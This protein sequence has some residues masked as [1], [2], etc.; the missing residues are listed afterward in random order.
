MD[1]LKRISEEASIAIFFR[2]IASKKEIPV[3]VR[4][5]EKQ[6]EATMF[7]N[8]R[9]GIEPSLGF[10]N[11]S[12]DLKPKENIEI[13][14]SNNGIDFNFKTEITSSFD[15]I[16][17]IEIP[18][19]LFYSFSSINSDD[20]T[21]ESFG[22][23]YPGFKI[24]DEKAARDI[25]RENEL[26]K[27]NNIINLQKIIE[28]GS[29]AKGIVSYKNEK[30]VAFGS[31]ARINNKTFQGSQIISEYDTKIDTNPLTILHLGL[32]N[33]LINNADFEHYIS[34]MDSDKE[35]ILN[36]YSDAEKLINDENKFKIDMFE[37]IECDCNNYLPSN[38]SEDIDCAK[39]ENDEEFLEFCSRSIKPIECKSYSYN[40]TDLY[41]QSIKKKYKDLGLVAERKIWR[42]QKHGKVLA[43]AVAESYPDGIIQKG[44]SDLCRIHLTN[45]NADLLEILDALIK[46]AKVFFEERNKDTF[47]IY[48]KAGKELSAAKDIPGLKYREPIVRVLA[49]KDGLIEYK[50]LLM[51]ELIQ[52]PKNYPLTQA[53]LAIWQTEK[54]YPGT[55]FGNIPGIV[56]I[57]EPIDRVQLE[58]AINLVI[59]NNDG[60]RIKINEENGLPSQFISKYKYENFDYM[61]FSKS[62]GLKGLYKWDEYKNGSVFKL[63]DSEL[64]YFTIFKLSDNEGGFYIKTHHLISDAWTSS[65]LIISKV[66]EL[67]SSF[68]KPG[69]V[70]K[71]MPSY[72]DYI[73]SENDYKKSTVFK[74]N[75]E[76]WNS[77]F[78]TVPELIDL[79]PASSLYK[80]T[81]AGR[82]S[83]TLTNQASLKINEFCKNTGSSPFSVFLS[84]LSVYMER[85][86]SKGDLVLG[87]PILNRSNFREKQTTG[88]FISTVPVRLNVNPKNKFN[89]FLTYVN[90][91]WKQILKNQ[92]YPY[93]LILD[94]FRKKNKLNTNLYDVV[95]SYQNTSHIKAE[96]E[97]SVDW[98]FNHSQTCSLAI[99][100]SNRDGDDRYAIDY[101]YLVDVF[102]SEEIERLFEQMMIL[103]EDAIKAPEKEIAKLSLLSEKEENEILIEFNKTEENYS[104]DKT[105][106]E[107]F[108]EQAKKNPNKTAV[109]FNSE[110]L[111]YK[112]LN[113]KANQLA[114]ILRD[115]GIGPD[116]IVAIMIDRSIEMI[117]G[118]LSVL[119]AGGAY[120]PIDS[121]YPFERKKY[122]LDDS[123]AKILLSQ[124]NIFDP[125][126]FKE[127]V[128]LIDKINTETEKKENLLNKC[129]SDDLA[130][131]IYTSGSTGKP[132]GVMVEHR[133]ISNLK[134]FFSQKLKI[135]EKDRI[136]QFAS[137]SFDAS[138]WEIFMSLLLGATL[139]IPSHEVIR[140]TAKF[141]DYLNTNSITIA[142][143][144]PTYLTH[145]KPERVNTLRKLVTAGSSISKEL[146]N[147]WREKT[148]YINAY[149][150][151]ETTICAT[152]WES[153][154]S[155]KNDNA[156]PI[157][158]PINNTKIY[159]LDKNSDL[160]PI[161][162][163]GELCVS[164]DTLAR[165]YINKE[166][167]TNEKFVDNPFLDNMKMYRTGDLARWLPN[168]DIEFL[169]RID[170]QIKL[171]GFRIELDEIENHLSSYGPIKESIV[172]AKD[173]KN[174]EKYICGYYVSDKQISS[175]DIRQYLLKKLPSFMVPAFFV[176]LD[177]M[178][179]NNSGKIDTALLP[180]PSGVIDAGIEFEAPH[181]SNE[182]IL[183]MIWKEIL[184]INRIGINNNFFELGGD[185]LKAISLVS[186]IQ[187]EFNKEISISEIFK[188]PTIK[189]MSKLFMNEIENPYESI[190]SVEER[191]FYPASHAQ[192]RMYLLNNMDKESVSYNIPVV[193]N[194]AGRI[195]PI[196]LENAINKLFSR[197]EMFRTTFH[198]V[199]GEIVQKINKEYK[200][201]LENNR[202]Q[203]E[204][205]ESYEKKLAKPF[206]LDKLP[207]FRAVLINEEKD[208]KLFIDMHHIISD[209]VTYGVVFNE[210]NKLYNGIDLPLPNIRYRDF[211]VWQNDMLLSDKVNRQ[212]EYWMKNYEGEIPVLNMP[213]DFTRKNVQVFDGNRF[214]F[215]AER[216]LFNDI[217][218]LA[219]KTGTTL[220]MILLAN[221]YVLLSKY[222]SQNDI[223]IG[224]PIAGRNHSDLENVVGMFVNTLPIRCKPDGG[225]TFLEF[226]EEV[227]NNTLMA[228]ENQDF[229]F[230]EL[231][232][233][234]SISRDSNRNPLFDVMFVLQ[235]SEGS[236]INFCGCKAGIKELGLK[237]SKFDIT[238]QSRK[239]GKTIEFEFE[240]ATSLFKNETITKM[241]EYYL[242]VIKAVTENPD[243]L[244]CDIEM[245]DC[246]EREKMIKLSTATSTEYPRNKTIH[247]LFEEQVE[248]YPNKIAVTFS[249]RSLTYKE[250]NE[251]ANSLAHILRGKG[252]KKDSIVAVLSERSIE[253]IIGILGT[254]KAGGAYLPINPD[255]PS[256]RID[257]L[258]KD[259][260]AKIILSYNNPKHIESEKE[261][262][263]LD[264]QTIY[265][266]NKENLK[267]V[268]SPHDLIY[269]MYT[270]GSTGTPK[271]V[272]VEHRNVVRLV[273]NTNFIELDENDRILLT[274]SVVF[275][276]T[277]FEIWSSLLNGLS[278]YLVDENTILNSEKLA[279]AL[280]KYKIST[281]WL[282]SSLFNQLSKQKPKMFSGLKNLLV[283]GDVLS[284]K[285]I[286][287]VR[288][289]NKSLNIINGYGPTENTTFSLCHKIIR[290]Y[291]ENIP[292]GKPIS[293]SSVFI[294][295]KCKNLQPIGIPGEIYVGGDGISR[296]YLNNKELT[297][298]KFIA[299][300]FV[301][302][303]IL[304]RTGD[305]GRWLSEG[306][307]EFLGRVDS[308]VKIRGYRIELGEIENSFLNRFHVREVV[309]VDKQDS[310]GQKYLC[311]YYSSDD[312]IPPKEIR[313]NLLEILPEYMVPSYFVRLDRIPLTQNGK[314][315][316]KALP[317]PDKNN[318]IS[319]EYETPANEIE[320]K[321]S[322]LFEEVIGVERVGR[323][324]G[325]FELGGDSLSAMRVIAGAYQYGWDINMQDFYRYK[326]LKTLSKKIKGEVIHT[327]KKEQNSL[328]YDD[329]MGVDESFV[330]DSSN[331]YEKKP[332]NVFLTG[333]TGFLGMHL[334]DKL[335]VDSETK[336]YCLVRG[337]SLSIAKKRF[338]KTLKFY[339][340]N[341]YIELLNKRIFVI[342]G[343]I[344]EENLG[345][346]DEKYAETGK[347]IDTMIHT[348]AV[349][350]HYGDYAE[351][352]RINIDGTN[353]VIDFCKRFSI[354]LIHVSTISVIKEIFINR[355]MTYEFAKNE[356]NVYVRSKLEAEN[357]ICKAIK[358]GLDAVVIRVGNLTGR[359]SDG[360]F[361]Q[362]INEN[363]FYNVLKSIIEL[364]KIDD[365]TVDR[366]IEFT[367]V[368]ECSKAIIE[369]IQKEDMKQRIFHIY[370]N[371]MISM[372][373][374]VK[375]LNEFGMKI[376]IVDANSF[377][378]FLKTIS[379]K[380]DRRVQMTGLVNNII[381]NDSIPSGAHLTIK[382]D[383]SNTFL[384]ES[385]FEWPK[386]ESN[387][388][389]KVINHMREADYI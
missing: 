172:V 197:H 376:D 284:P 264:N 171:R 306:C 13:L 80:S 162:A 216:T 33:R 107:L 105:I 276:A 26:F 224:S 146:L 150:P 233:N 279:D 48:L 192:K 257:Y 280:R 7:F 251:R 248:K 318:N 110:S 379:K 30:P 11:T 112:E 359:Y 300:P 281:L 291:K 196:R 103:L 153:R 240:Y 176:Q 309:V 378:E 126:L 143:L 111:T 183:L 231:I 354:R 270:S 386:I 344:T 262:I 202:I 210:L 273:K 152:I 100:I 328:K 34:Y 350:K 381:S 212:Y 108:E 307:V 119:K 334:L 51:G 305:M 364:Q 68:D 85:V 209:G 10:S 22:K 95:I 203:K 225:K 222:S 87:T 41:L 194:I 139:Y 311:L 84:I 97:Y 331:F 230:E 138:V 325:F 127:N 304:Y 215:E 277:T 353:E 198:M 70:Y 388:L 218:V 71:K 299:N 163:E 189:E 208:Q 265:E 37:S 141:E 254:L 195:D 166:D 151:T 356:S 181:N 187:K 72:L 79:K 348:A 362:N 228:F 363:N 269:I 88:V 133:G 144:P 302:G 267:N 21:A 333:A 73:S 389:L 236:E 170:N 314:A 2:K 104:Q 93:N 232:K 164:G 114:R 337:E 77:K 308:Q 75:E 165:G 56:R 260:K 38:N 155:N 179:L 372:R 243:K 45:G 274:G 191:D 211:S 288:N 201:R 78:D 49:S 239:K 67:Y 385:G 109:V 96:S 375:I 59:Q 310:K 327:S 9:H 98:V 193:L 292:I 17:T 235:N 65:N 365:N 128:I 368:D 298:S 156:V 36:F 295:D 319:N 50:N 282:T 220:Y 293:N 124:S 241:A 130:Y 99:H 261:I 384:K 345:L 336:V 286:N 184:E 92:K 338:L 83:F 244:L 90:K 101:D 25:Q 29:I 326:T 131:L 147:L 342:C 219:E 61:D 213:T 135:S 4:L 154:Y 323:N 16:C 60:M 20:D 42:I 175:N 377:N 343:D 349:V 122:L 266:G 285:H 283:G 44:T 297:E 366:K 238:L 76:F 157:G 8:S 15:G 370:N 169:G 206:R 137:S 27:K 18:S 185:S 180:E 357:Q 227:K 272:M 174:N 132:K 91:E 313:E 3:L 136:I 46:S 158:K 66:M 341:N 168:G 361:Q 252:V 53:Q 346:S 5:D 69:F 125:E 221:F 380:K 102:D 117:I 317:N 207:L 178:P 287:L 159:I 234:L 374:V 383:I 258:I 120:L 39:P 371:N 43:Y 129:S 140:S 118:I 217:E 249:D 63:I 301:E 121:E 355:P 14:F 321:L 245:I 55:G 182:E 367:P 200:F 199:N 32:C 352:E 115:R 62:G 373:N 106:H 81:G 237:I 177:K 360:K 113:E 54:V 316:R 52:L 259:S 247:K 82:K 255:Y 335:L 161:G 148:E 268:N 358:S 253:M 23:T 315:D 89:D 1:S 6:I 188:S 160:V 332:K 303:D 229:Q 47:N 74:E 19:N 86:T 24:L 142:T 123:S 290:D 387:Y 94:S 40:K 28:N 35:R 246:D 369:I 226:L 263:K 204:K 256:E 339:F 278:L 351:F 167:L 271:G 275:D 250:L 294:L 296:G 12:I 116:S 190:P 340:G 173:D 382:S 214:R 347:N 64:F 312:D 186:K 322:K 205:T 289:E 31:Y 58:R 57:K 149:G 145:L 320:K 330:W 242:N 223:I 324:D 329:T 134:T